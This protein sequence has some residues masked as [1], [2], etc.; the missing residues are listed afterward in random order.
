MQFL[1]VGHDGTDDKAMERR[2]KARP[3][4]IELGDK[5]FKEG[6]FWY[7]AALWDE[8]EQMIGSMYLVDFPSEK[9]L[10]EWLKIEPYMVGGVW[11][12]LEIQRCNVRDPWLFNRPKKWFEERLAAG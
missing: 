5:L 1:I 7:G 8:N 11:K 4:H 3:A 12:K 2:M 9:E 6:I 10:H